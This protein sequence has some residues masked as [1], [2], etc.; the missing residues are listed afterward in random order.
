VPILLSGLREVRP[1]GVPLAFRQAQPALRRPTERDVGSSQ[2]FCLSKCEPLAPRQPD[3][4][5]D[6]GDGD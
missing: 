3:P 4:N 2:H 5:G 1:S 6:S